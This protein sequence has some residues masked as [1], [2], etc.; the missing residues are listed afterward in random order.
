MRSARIREAVSTVSE[1]LGRLLGPP[2]GTPNVRTPLATYAAWFAQV[3]LDL[4]HQCLEK[5]YSLSLA[6]KA[7]SGYPANYYHHLSC[8]LM[9]RFRV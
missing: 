6:R 1:K 4:E 2:S 8:S 3:F 7:R 5:S 9:L